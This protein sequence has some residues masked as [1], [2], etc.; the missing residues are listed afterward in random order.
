M[1]E[2]ILNLPKIPTWWN[3]RVTIVVIVILSILL[4]AWSVW[5]LPVDYDEPVYLKAASDYA[6]FL[7]EGNIYGLINYQGNVEHP[8][9]GKLIYSIPFLILP[10]KPDNLAYLFYVRSISAF[11]GV[12]AVLL[13]SIINPLA[14]FLFSLHSMTLKYTSEAYLEAFPLFAMLLCVYLLLESKKKPANWKI[15]ISSISFGLMAAGKYSYFFIVIVIAYIWFKILKKKIS[16]FII[17][18][19]M[20]IIMFFAL[21]PVLWINPLNQIITSLNFHT[22]YSQSAFVQS[23]NYPWYQPLVYISNSV[24][25]H[26]QVFFFFTTDELVFY[27]TIFGL[28]FEVKEKS[29]TFVWLLTGLVFLFVWPTK[30]PQYTLLVSP[31]FCIIAGNSLVRLWNWIKPRDDYWNYLDAM[32]PKPPKIVWWL[33]GGIILVLFFGKVGFEYR[34]ALGRKGWTNFNT[35]NSPLFNNI[36]NQIMRTEPNELILATNSGFLIWHGDENLPWRD[37]ALH[38]DTRN[39]PLPSNRVT[40][41]NFDKKNKIYWIGTD[42]GMVRYDGILWYLDDLSNIPCQICQ[43]NVIKFDNERNV[44]AGTNEG[45]FFYDQKNWKRISNPDDKGDLSM[46]ST[47]LFQND[48]RFKRL[49]VGTFSGVSM[50]DFDSDVWINEIWDGRFLGWGGIT[51]LIELE[52]HRI[53]AT[54]SGGGIGL[55][56]G[57]WQFLKNTNSPFKSNIVN[58][59]IQ[60]QDGSVWFGFAFSTEPGGYLMKLDINNKW[61]KYSKNNS[62]YLESEPLD[63]YLDDNGKLWIATNGNGIQTFLK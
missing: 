45:L 54:T 37:E 46:V 39:S 35:N 21:N 1:E 26:P 63:F 16:E 19:L 43:V 30:W 57:S 40:A 18:L 44:W 33:I 10:Q 50:Y 41:L 25:W 52:D 38:F 27:I 55:F 36:V 11:F 29:W 3:R 42:H 9:L 34:M 49:W 60:G 58:T 4:H 5:Q 53:V 32:L 22:Q 23:F 20:A 28:W 2:R 24:Q 56:D 8:A 14:G 6:Y 61:Q 62:G 31:V 48:E 15:L 17:Y 13:L 12:L 7:R 51:D 59:A 47:I